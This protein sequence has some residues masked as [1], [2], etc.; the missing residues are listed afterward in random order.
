MPERPAHAHT[1][2]DAHRADRFLTRPRTACPI[3]LTLRVDSPDCAQ[4]RTRLEELLRD[5]PGLRIMTVSHR[6]GVA[7][8]ALQA[9]RD[10]LDTMLHRIMAGIPGA[11]F[12]AIQPAVLAAV[13]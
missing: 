2:R 1:A 13:H 3:S 11:E 4:A 5:I 10:A 9:S 8:L 7:T 12:G 6:R